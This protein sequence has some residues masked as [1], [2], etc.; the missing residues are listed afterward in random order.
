MAVVDFFTRNGQPLETNTYGIIAAYMAGY[1]V[2]KERGGNL[3]KMQLHA[4]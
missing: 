1:K 2:H 4:T 3:T